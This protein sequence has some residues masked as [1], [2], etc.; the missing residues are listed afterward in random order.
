MVK[1]I[2]FKSRT[3]ESGQ[4][5]FALIVQGGAEP[6]RSAKTGKLYFSAK[7]ASVPSTFD[8]ETCQSLI[9]C[10]FEGSVRKVACDPYNYTIGETG[11]VIEL[12]HCYEYVNEEL[13]IIEDQ[14]VPDEK[15][16]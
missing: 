11:E 1:V 15:V 13:T 7:T 2:D 16:M 12:S 4:E 3:N 8:E 6:I 5:F 9:G 10:S 14:M